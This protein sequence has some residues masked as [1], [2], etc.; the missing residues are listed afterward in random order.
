MDG[1]VLARAGRS[2][3]AARPVDAAALVVQVRNPLAL[4][5][6]E[7]AAIVERCMRA[8]MAIYAG[9]APGG[10]ASIPSRIASQLGL[11][12]ALCADDPQ[13]HGSARIPWHTAG[14]ANPAGFPVRATVIHCA[15]AGDGGEIAL[16]DPELAWLMLRGEGECFVQALSRDDAFSVPQREGERHAV[17]AFDAGGELRMRFSEHRDAQR[18]KCDPSVSEAAARLRRLLDRDTACIVRTRLAAGMGVVSNN[19]LMTRA[20]LPDARTRM[21]RASFRERVPGTE[22]ARD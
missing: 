20:M 6:A 19:V 16:L 12:P 2:V 22:A 10:D 8:N 11:R 21:V 18:W 5:R 9:P 3:F 14:H 13:M 7:R 4:S 17:F 15:S 1:L